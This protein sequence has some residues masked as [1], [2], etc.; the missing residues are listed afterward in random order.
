MQGQG[1]KISMTNLNS[2][3]GAKK[4]KSKKRPLPKGARLALRIV[5]LLIFPVLC[6]IGLY[7]GLRIGYVQ[8]GDGAPEDVMKWETWKHMLDLV[9]ADS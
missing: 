7:V 5:R 8:F 6:V 2:N 3:A 9:F 4:T 1:V